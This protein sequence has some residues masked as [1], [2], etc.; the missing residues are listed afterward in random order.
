MRKLLEGTGFVEVSWTDKTEPAMTWFAEF[1][2]SLSPF[3]PLGI[4]VVMGP[5]FLEMAKNFA[6][7]LQDGRVRLIQAVFRRG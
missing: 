2:A 3:P 7:N 4:S 1:Q 6:Q 5:Q